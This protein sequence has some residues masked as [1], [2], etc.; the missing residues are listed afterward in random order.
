MANSSVIFSGQSS[1]DM[2]PEMES[3]MTLQACQHATTF[4]LWWKVTKVK[5]KT[6]VDIEYKQEK[7]VVALISASSHYQVP[8]QAKIGLSDHCLLRWA[9]CLKNDAV[10]MDSNR[11][12]IQWTLPLSQVV[13]PPLHLMQVS[14]MLCSSTVSLAVS[15]PKLCHVPRS[16]LPWNLV[17]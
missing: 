8:Q 17:T 7:M 16:A 2:I 4:A 10:S 1:E 12:K 5:P 11:W 9:V 3:G 15:P 14:I 6:H 13:A